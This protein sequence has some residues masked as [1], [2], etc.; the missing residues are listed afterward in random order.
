MTSIFGR[1]DK[2]KEEEEEEE[3]KKHVEFC[4]TLLLK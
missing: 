1:L 4:N 3:G 2:K